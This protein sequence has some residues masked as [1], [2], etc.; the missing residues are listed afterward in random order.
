METPNLKASEWKDAFKWNYPAY[1]F[2]TSVYLLCALPYKNQYY[3]HW[4]RFLNYFGDGRLEAYLPKDKML[5]VGRKIIRELLEGKADFLTEFEKLYVK[6][7]ATIT[8]CEKTRLGLKTPELDG[9]WKEVQD[10]LSDVAGLLFSFDYA[11]NEYMSKMQNENLVEFSKLKD[12]I[13]EDKPSFLDEAKTYY[14]ELYVKHKNDGDNLYMQ[15]I[16]KFGWFQN[17]YFGKF[18]ITKE[19][20][21]EFG[22]NI[23]AEPKKKAH[24]S[25]KDSG[26]YG[27]LVKTASTAISFRDDKKK[28]L[29]VAVDLMDTWLRKVCEEN[30]WK[31][32]TMR[33]LTV[34]EVERSLKG[35][36]NLIKK[37][38]EYASQ[39]VRYGLMID[40][41]YV[42][43]TPMLWKEVE[44]LHV[45]GELKEFKGMAASKG[46]TQG[47]AKIVFDPNKDGHKF[48][49]GDILVASMTRPE[50]LPLMGKAA[51]FVTDEGGITCHAAIIAREMGKPCVIGTKIAT[52]VLKDGYVVEV[53]ADKGIVKILK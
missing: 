27:L 5:Q 50:F 26:E 34:H 41:G 16:T 15:F 45:V 48:K 2:F 19:W 1:P 52:Q 39:K 30:G 44:S 17:S 47:I 49:E 4:D 18:E 35:N 46:K 13:R 24:K 21:N 6:V 8:L 25:K 33:W 51:A 11:L 32:E 22:K 38:E 37:A 31:F 20:L 40:N 10:T 3:I 29:L 9:W 12:L 53:D 14:R 42:D 28:L 43:F 23:L 7:N 36:N